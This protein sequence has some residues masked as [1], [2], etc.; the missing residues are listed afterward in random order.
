MSEIIEQLELEHLA[1]YLPYELKYFSPAHESK[2]YL[3]LPKDQSIETMSVISM[4]SMV[5]YPS[6]EKKPIFRP[7]SDLVKKIEFN[8]EEIVPLVKILED[9][10]QYGN[11]GINTLEIGP[12]NVSNRYGPTP[13]GYFIKYTVPKVMGNT[14]YTFKYNFKGNNFTFIKNLLNLPETNPSKYSHEPVDALKVITSLYRMHFDIKNL[15]EKGLALDVNKV[16]IIA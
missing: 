14:E 1:P 4:T 9:S 16:T 12:Y 10:V 13:D 8:G 6:S 3:D 2:S 5:N 11:C 7:L 15:I